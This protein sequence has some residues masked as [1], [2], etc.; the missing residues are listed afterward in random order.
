M[1]VRPPRGQLAQIL[2]LAHK[3]FADHRL[4]AT[5]SGECHAP[6]QLVFQPP[7]PMH[8]AGVQQQLLH[9]IGQL[10][11]QAS[12]RHG[13]TA[14]QPVAGVIIQPQTEIEEIQLTGIQLPQLLTERRRGTQPH[15]HRRKQGVQGTGNIA[16]IFFQTFAGRSG[17]VRRQ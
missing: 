5:Q 3:A 9:G 17:P 12:G 10:A 6:L 16:Q 14:G 4:Q 1:Q 11:Q 7:L 15:G 13:L 8:A 2:W